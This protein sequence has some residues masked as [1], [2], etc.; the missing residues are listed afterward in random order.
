MLSLLVQK[1]NQDKYLVSEDDEAF[2]IEALLPFPPLEKRAILART[3]LTPFSSCRITGRDNLD[4]F[5]P[6][7][8]SS[9]NSDR[10]RLPVEPADDFRLRASK[11]WKI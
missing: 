7:T 4:S 5:D 8:F 2:W 1:S 9:R 11:F 6:P 3:P 10:S